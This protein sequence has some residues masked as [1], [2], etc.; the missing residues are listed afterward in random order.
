VFEAFFCFTPKLLNK[1]GHRLCS[2]LILEKRE[3]FL[4]I[5]S[6]F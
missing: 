3:D 2:S 1:S 6:V 5:R 4:D